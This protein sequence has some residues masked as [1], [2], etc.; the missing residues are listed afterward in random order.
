MKFGLSSSVLSK[1]TNTRFNQNPSLQTNAP[2]A[3][4]RT[5]KPAEHQS[6]A[7]TKP[8]SSEDNNDNEEGG[9][10]EEDEEEPHQAYSTV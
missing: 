5:K 2:S 6:Q 8:T 1:N 9:S 10:E 3:F 7:T 4:Q